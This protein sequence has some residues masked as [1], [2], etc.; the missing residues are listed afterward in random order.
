MLGFMHV[1]DTANPAEVSAPVKKT[2][3]FWQGFV[4]LFLLL[5]IKFHIYLQEKTATQY[6]S[7]NSMNTYKMFQ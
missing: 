1:G 5:V 2:K 3:N 7:V 6:F 4:G